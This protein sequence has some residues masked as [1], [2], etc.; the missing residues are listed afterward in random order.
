MCYFEKGIFCLIPCSCYVN[1]FII[2]HQRASWNTSRAIAVYN[3]TITETLYVHDKST[4]F[5]NVFSSSFA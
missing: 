4:C 2:I 3:P 1:I 5:C